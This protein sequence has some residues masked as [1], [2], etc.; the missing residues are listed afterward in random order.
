MSRSQRGR[1]TLL[2]LDLQRKLIANWIE[3]NDQVKQIKDQ[4][5]AVGKK[6][7]PWVL[8]SVGCPRR[9]ACIPERGEHALVP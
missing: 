9:A 4:H 5:Q 6:E 2:T 7:M 1:S 3:Y 8:I